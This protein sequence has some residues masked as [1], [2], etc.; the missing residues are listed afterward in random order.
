MPANAGGFRGITWPLRGDVVLC[1]LPLSTFGLDSFPKD[2]L[3]HRSSLLDCCKQLQ[4]MGL[5]WSAMCWR[6]C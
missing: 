6:T 2:D 1:F 5:H 3:H 4:F